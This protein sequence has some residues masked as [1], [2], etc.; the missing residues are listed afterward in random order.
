MKKNIGIGLDV[1]DLVHVA[2]L[3]REDILACKEVLEENP[4]DIAAQVSM[5]KSKALLIKI[6]IAAVEG[7]YVNPQPKPTIFPQRS[8]LN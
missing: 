6:T 3:M 5:D 4:L 1:D 7:E 8:D 2:D